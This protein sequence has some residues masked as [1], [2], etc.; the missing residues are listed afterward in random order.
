MILQCVNTSEASVTELAL[1]TRP[2]GVV[3]L[4]VTLKTV[5][6]VKCFTTDGAVVSV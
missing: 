2:V 6:T 1:D 5:G 3:N 4:K